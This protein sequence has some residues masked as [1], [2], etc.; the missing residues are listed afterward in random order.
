M[1]IASPWKGGEIVKS[2]GF[3]F[4]AAL[5]YCQTN[6][7]INLNFFLLDGNRSDVKQEWTT[8]V[9]L[10][11]CGTH[12]SFWSKNAAFKQSLIKRFKQGERGTV[13]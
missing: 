12:V 11:R 4:C 9:A 5:E 3:Y 13:S 10:I 2:K 8:Q 1:R 6:S 7:L